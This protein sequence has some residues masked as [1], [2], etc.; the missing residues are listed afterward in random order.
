MPATQ[1]QTKTVDKFWSFKNSADQGTTPPELILYG[2]ISQ[3]SWWGDDITPRA[4]SDDLIALGDVD[5]IVVRINSNGGDV[6]A[7]NAIYTRLKDHRA[8]ITVKVDG[9]AASA[10]TIVAMA[11]DTI[12]IPGNGVFMVHNP[13]MG[14][15]GYYDE[16]EF[17]AMCAELKVIKQSIINGYA[18][19]TGKDKDEIAQIMSREKWYTGP[20]AVAAGFC[21]KL[22]FQNA[23]TVI[24]NASKVIVNSVAY[25]LTRY[26]NMPV[27]II[28]KVT[29]R[30]DEKEE[31]EKMSDEIRTT[32]QIRAAYPSLVASLREEAAREERERIKAIDDVAMPGFEDLVEEA[33]YTKPATAAEVATRIIAKQ[34][35]QGKTFLNSREKDV[36]DSGM[37]DVEDEPE[38]KVKSK[39]K[40]DIYDEA[41]DRVLPITK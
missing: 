26:P 31:E 19:K 4:F 14:A 5:E 7:A 6:F 9:W 36:E 23:N 39:S 29:R 24:E 3:D 17:A 2:D 27:S 13:K 20:E 38:D 15:H 25:D 21:D 30:A 12:E 16:D 28:N 41:I 33:K 1:K 37:C 8:R 35:Q 40:R 32:D 22:M 11:G 18:L 34:K 10:A